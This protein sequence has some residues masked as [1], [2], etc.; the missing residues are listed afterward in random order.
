MYE[1][2][3]SDYR[4]DLKKEFLGLRDIPELT[5]A[6]DEEFDKYCKEQFKEFME[7]VAQ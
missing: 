1:D 5:D 6:D 2:F 3:L 7:E 4:I